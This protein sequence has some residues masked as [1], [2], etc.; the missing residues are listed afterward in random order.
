MIALVLS[1][2]L[3]KRNPDAAMVLSLLVCA[4]LLSSALGFLSPLMNFV[5]DLISL[6]ALSSDK[7]QILMK[8]TALGLISQLAGLLCA[9]AG[10]SALGKGIEIAAVCAILWI[11]LPLMSALMELVQTILGQI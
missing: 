5:Q 11:S 9:D 8:A 1:I 4:M 2:I 10:N 3:E 6:G 7:I